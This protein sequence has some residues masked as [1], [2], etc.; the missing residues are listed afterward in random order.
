MKE[1]VLILKKKLKAIVTSRIHFWGNNI[2]VNTFDDRV[3]TPEL[4]F[5][6]IK[7]IKKIRF[8][9]S[10]IN[11]LHNYLS[12]KGF[13]VLGGFNGN[14]LKRISSKIFNFLIRFN[15]KIVD[16]IKIYHLHYYDLKKA[17]KKND[18][19]KNDFENGEIIILNSFEDWKK[20]DR[21]KKHVICCINGE[22]ELEKIKKYI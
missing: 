2:R 7:N 17:I 11:G 12:Y 14:N 20:Y 1:L 16:D 9:S 6:I 8:K 5:R 18:L 21:R 4:Q 15:Y 19:R 22:K 13:K 10:D 3:W